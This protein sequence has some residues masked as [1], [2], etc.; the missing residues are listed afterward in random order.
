MGWKA[1][2][3]GVPLDDEERIETLW[4]IASA[5][6]TS[7]AGGDD[8]LSRE[9]IAAIVGGAAAGEAGEADRRG[10]PDRHVQRERQDSCAEPFPPGAP[11]TSRPGSP[12]GPKQHIEED[13]R[14]RCR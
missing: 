3:L 2:Q 13:A 8:H 14:R 12:D 9:V 7:G 4:A 11:D 1:L 10:D 6:N 5:A